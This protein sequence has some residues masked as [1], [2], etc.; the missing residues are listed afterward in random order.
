MNR[1]IDSAFS[2]L[3][4]LAHTIKAIYILVLS[5]YIV[6]TINIAHKKVPFQVVYIPRSPLMDFF[7]NVSCSLWSVRWTRGSRA[8]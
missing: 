4:T 3:M 5:P 1:F 7:S 2:F 8:C 6:I